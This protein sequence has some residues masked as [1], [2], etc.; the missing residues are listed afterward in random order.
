MNGER[1]GE[2]EREIVFFQFFRRGRPPD[3]V[4]R[5]GVFFADSNPWG[6]LF[7]IFSSHGAIL[8]E[9]A[10]VRVRER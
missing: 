5:K 7:D 8:G 10:R 9:R 4:A 2:M 3:A 6:F 1:E